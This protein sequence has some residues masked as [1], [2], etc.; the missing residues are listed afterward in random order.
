M[1]PRL[2]ISISRFGDG[3]ILKDGAARLSVDG[4]DGMMEMDGI[5]GLRGWL[6]KD[7]ISD[8]MLLLLY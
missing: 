5:G 2:V 4:D 7:A 6:D 8:W 1:A 3:V